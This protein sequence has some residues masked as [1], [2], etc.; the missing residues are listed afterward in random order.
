[1]LREKR[2]ELVEGDHVQLVVEIHVIGAR[3]R[4]NKNIS[5]G[6]EEPPLP[7]VSQW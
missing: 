4:K 7:P 2:R 6:K 1:M 3:T 5:P